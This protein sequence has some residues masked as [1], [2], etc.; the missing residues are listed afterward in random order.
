MRFTPL[1]AAGG[2]S[3]SGSQEAPRTSAAAGA[4]SGHGSPVAPGL[5]PR[6][7]FRT[8]RAPARL[9]ICVVLRAQAAAPTRGWRGAQAQLLAGR[10]A[11]AAQPLLVLRVL[12]G[13]E[14]AHASREPGSQGVADTPA[15][16]RAL[17]RS[18]F[19]I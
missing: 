11:T 15:S 14:G 7:S 13:R 19:A 17:P 10:G 6:V 3:H 18:C 4:D 9:S 5:P 8:R 12:T 16:G 2:G 1:W